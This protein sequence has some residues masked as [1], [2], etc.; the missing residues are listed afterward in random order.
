P[1]VWGAAEGGMFP[2]RQFASPT[3]HRYWFG[4]P[5]LQTM[6]WPTAGSHQARMLKLKENQFIYRYH[7]PPGDERW[8][9]TEGIGYAPKEGGMSYGPNVYPQRKAVIVGTP[10]HHQYSGEAT[11]S[12]QNLLH[13]DGP[14]AS[15][16]RDVDAAE[17]Y[18]VLGDEHFG[19]GEFTLA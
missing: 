16:D 10:Q 2:R 6:T 13:F 11:G 7:V 3:V 4:A 1:L 5:Y 14:Y 18:L 8:G 19:K 15:T 9:W 12:Y 17:K